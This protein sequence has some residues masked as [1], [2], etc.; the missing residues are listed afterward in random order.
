MNITLSNIVLQFHGM[1]E[2]LLE[3]GTHQLDTG[4]RL[5]IRGGSGTGKTSLLHVMAGL[6]DPYRGS[7]A[8]DDRSMNTLSEGARCK[9]R[10]E[11]IGFIFQKLNILGHLTA[12]ENVMLSRPGRSISRKQAIEALER[13]GVDSLAD[14]Q[15]HFLSL[16]EQQRVAVARV[17]VSRPPVILADEPTSSLDDRNAE[18]VMDTLFE[19]IQ[20]GGEPS[21]KSK[22]RGI[23][24]VATHDARI[25]PRF[26]QQWELKEGRI[27]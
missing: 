12:A 17:V 10:R 18:R 7:A 2:P 13:V 25:R 26:E 27:Q 21:S 4:T 22:P 15:A 11:N 24:I 6:L 8:I 20:G 9:L 1:K 5:L 16:G 23:L 14:Q 3:T 19:V